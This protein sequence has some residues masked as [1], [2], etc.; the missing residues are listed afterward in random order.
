VDELST[1]QQACVWL[2]PAVSGRLPRDV[3]DVADGC[4]VDFW[5]RWPRAPAAA[6]A[7]A[8]AAACKRMPPR[9]AAP[10]E[11]AFMPPGRGGI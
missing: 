6:D 3:L 4:V 11:V 1:S 10:A 8:V 9:P 2:S 7:V 5:T